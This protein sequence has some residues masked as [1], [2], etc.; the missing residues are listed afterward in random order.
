MKRRDV[1]AEYL[2]TIRDENIDELIRIHNIYCY[3]VNE[4]EN[5]I[6]LMDTFNNLY[7]DMTP[8]EIADMMRVYGVNFTSEDKYFNGELKSFS[9]ISIEDIKTENIAIYIDTHDDDIKNDSIKL[10]LKEMED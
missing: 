3:Q 7:Q 1:I 6:Y 10:I 2:E 5:C 4:T 8:L 9:Y